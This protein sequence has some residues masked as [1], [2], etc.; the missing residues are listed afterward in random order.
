MQKPVIAAAAVIAMLAA[1]AR[2]HAWG[3]EA[4]AFVMA[5]AIAL[6]PAELRPFFEANRT[7]L[8]EHTIDPDLWR[9]AGF[10]EE[11]PR[12][13]IDIDAYG[14]YPFKELPRDYAAA[15]KKYGAETLRKNGLL[16]WRAAEVAG[17]LRRAFEQLPKGSVSAPNEVRFFST[18]LAHYVG[19]GHVPFHGVTNYDGQL[20][21]QTGIHSRW[22]GELFTRYQQKLSVKPAP[23]HPIPNMRDFMFDTAL[24]S[25]Q[26]AQGA[27]DADRA[28]IGTRDEYDDRYFN[29]FFAGTR[30]VLERR[31]RESI[32]A[33][34]SAIASAW[35]QAGRPAVPVTPPKRVERRRAR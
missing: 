31:L 21:G 7:F 11:L 12:H 22:E 23:I 33:V 16:P 4:H 28:A 27:L 24:T 13:F 32:T 29:A 6:L 17:W 19:D 3:F 14:A 10:A 26:L 35:E 20:T 34:A 8:I 1:P 15:L 2:A 9:T 5:R 25:F 30:P 18:V